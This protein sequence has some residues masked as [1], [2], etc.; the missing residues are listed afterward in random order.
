[1]SEALAQLWADLFLVI[2][3]FVCFLLLAERLTFGQYR[4]P[5]FVSVGRGTKHEARSTRLGHAMRRPWERHL[6]QQVET[7]PDAYRF[8]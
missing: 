6:F 7:E 8:S 4:S 1:V 2:Y 5:A 3:L